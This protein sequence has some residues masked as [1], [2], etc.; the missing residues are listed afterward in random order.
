MSHTFA[1]PFV[2]GAAFV[3]EQ[4]GIHEYRLDGNDLQI[5]LAPDSSAPVAGFMV[6]Y[7]VGSRNEA[8]GYTGATHLLEHLLFKG[9]EK[10]NKETGTTVWDLLET[11]GALVN[12]TTWNDRT[13]YFEVVPSAH[14]PTAIALEADRM[15]HARIREEDRASEMTVVRNE[16]ERGENVP[17]EAVD[18]QLWALAYQ[19]HPY[20]HSTIG[21]QSDIEQVPIERLE[22]FYRDFY[23]PDNATVTV[24]GG[25][26][27]AE[28]L[29]QIVREFGRHEKSTD[30][31]PPMYTTEPPQ[32][33]ERRAVVKRPGQNMLGIAYKI[34]QATHPDMP[35]LIILSLILAE[36]KT[37][38][39][40]RTL[41]DSARASE[42][43]AA[44]YQF[45]DPSLLSFYITLA[46][47]TTHT[48][49]EKLC[50]RAWTELIARGPT[51]EEVARAKRTVRA[52]I[53]LR[54]DGPYA[55]LS[56]LNEEIATGDWT[57]FATLPAA[58]ERVK[59]K[60]VQKAAKAYLIDDQS[61]IVAFHAT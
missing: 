3:R 28:T 51:A 44:C 54:R 48:E 9:S 40:Y 47:K 33:G 11:K 30:P 32:E 21:W 27:E 34:P 53:A 35:A 8:T 50:K 61:T 22:R 49:A 17:L 6:T 38:R 13:N 46:G 18:K 42:L 57:R 4:D 7:R 26:D 24:V 43:S 20:H 36:G 5:L 23:A 59:Q 45:K 2:P 16:F 56:A 58:L 60:D 29:S 41:V 10:F 14:L 55:L 25:F 37:S 31:L 15:R 52:D 12:A 19:A 1:P 39:L